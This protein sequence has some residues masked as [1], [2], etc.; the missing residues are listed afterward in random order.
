ML[1]CRII[2]TMP[3]AL[4]F[5]SGTGFGLGTGNPDYSEVRPR[6]T[7]ASLLPSGSRR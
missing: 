1:Y 6:H 7:T 2:H 3:A 4:P 5:G